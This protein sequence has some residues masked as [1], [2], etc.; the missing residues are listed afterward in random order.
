M[1]APLAPPFPALRS[2]TG[3]GQ[4]SM[5]ATATTTSPEGRIAFIQAGWHRE[6]VDQARISFIEELDANGVPATRVDIFDVPGSLEIPLQA[7]LLAQSGSYDIVV[8]A[9]FVIDGGIY[10]HDFVASAVID[11]IMR[12][13]LETQVPVLSIVLTPHRYHE[14]EE[15]HEFFMA[16]FKIKGREAARA[17]IATLRNVSAAR[18]LVAG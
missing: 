1:R 5:T 15:H 8:G 2:N 7:K 3:M 14:H 4:N 17:C 12:V 11:G 18:A 9:G 16:H 6:I 10:R 13:Q